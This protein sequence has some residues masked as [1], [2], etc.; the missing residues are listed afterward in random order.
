MVYANGEKVCKRD[1]RWYLS[2]V[3]RGFSTP[4]YRFGR[5]NYVSKLMKN[6]WEKI[7]L[8]QI[9]GDKVF[10]AIVSKHCKKFN[11]MIS[12]FNWTVLRLCF[13]QFLL[14]VLNWAFC[15]RFIHCYWFWCPLIIFR[16]E[17]LNSRNIRVCLDFLNVIIKLFQGG[18]DP[19]T[20]ALRLPASC[21]ILLRRKPYAQTKSWI[22]H[23]ICN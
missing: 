1:R 3:S 10:I 18:L 15:M 20:Q 12:M 13:N 6:S 2:G 21:R 8:I 22:G 5:P 23:C 16:L 19:V 11:F 9:V 14:P 4:V 17:V 7:S